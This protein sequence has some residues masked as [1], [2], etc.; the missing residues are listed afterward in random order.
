MC[1]CLEASLSD[2]GALHKFDVDDLLLTQ[3]R[4]E[5]EIHAFKKQL[6]HIN[7]RKNVLEACL[8]EEQ[9]SHEQESEE[10]TK[11]RV[12][13]DLLQS[14]KR[15]QKRKVE[16]LLKEKK[17]WEAARSSNR[18]P[19]D[20]KP[21]RIILRL[22]R[23]RF[24]AHYLSTVT[25]QNLQTRTY[26]DVR[27]A[28]KSCWPHGDRISPDEF[29]DYFS[30]QLCMDRETLAHIYY[31]VDHAWRLDGPARGRSTQADG[32]RSSSTSSGRSSS[33]AL[34]PGQTSLSAGKL[35]SNR[36][37]FLP[38]EEFAKFFMDPR[39]LHGVVKTPSP[40]TSRK[41]SPPPSRFTSPPGSPRDDS[42]SLT[43][44]SVEDSPRA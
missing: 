26:F 43:V 7:S 19:L 16:E 34:R 28:F 31:L 38:E 6:E 10:H 4:L 32:R 39:L 1:S 27:R 30:K 3:S 37:A 33:P 44:H 12:Q 25:D 23:Q 21:D 5:G 22:F 11:V 14:E 8:H 36:P 15:I 2:A 40:D 9:Q 17:N 13:M 35:R 20:S 42:R 29:C 24:E 18:H 41:N